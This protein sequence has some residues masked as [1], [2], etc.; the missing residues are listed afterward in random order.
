MKH[1]RN[2]WPLGIILAFVLFGL[3]T[4]SLI[5]VACSQ[6]IDL[7]SA[8]YYEQEIKFQKQIDR[9]DRTRRLAAQPAVAYDRLRGV[10]TISLPAEQ[11]R[12]LVNGR[13]QLYRP[14]T[15]G[16]DRELPLAL[17]EQGFQSVDASSL[18]A[19]LWKVRISWM[20]DDQEYFVDQKVVVGSNGDKA[21]HARLAIPTSARTA[22]PICS[23]G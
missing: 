11:A 1:P 14:S 6:K 3:G 22:T 10:I 15:A 23:N 5:V 2:F 16:L 19:G 12:R 21:P 8:N 9:V 18:R 13:I 4:A 20:S 7:V 17:N